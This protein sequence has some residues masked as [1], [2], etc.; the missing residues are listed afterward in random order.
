MR[1]YLQQPV[2]G[3]IVTQYLAGLGFSDPIYNRIRIRTPNFGQSRKGMNDIAD[4]SELDEE[5]P[6]VMTMLPK[7]LTMFEPIFCS[8]PEQI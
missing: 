7:I 1:I 2:D 4:G 8:V 6:H 3:G 5:D